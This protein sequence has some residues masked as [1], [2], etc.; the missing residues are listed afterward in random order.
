[1]GPPAGGERVSVPELAFLSLAPVYN[2]DE[3]LRLLPMI[4]FWHF[5]AFRLRWLFWNHCCVC[6]LL[7]TSALALVA[8]LTS[9]EGSSNMD[10][11]ALLLEDIGSSAGG[12]D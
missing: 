2:I 10:T 5:L 3:V 11:K 4:S 12:S 9:E 6:Y 7:S 1:M 8:A